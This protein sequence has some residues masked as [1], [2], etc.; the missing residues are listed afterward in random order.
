VAFLR[1]DGKNFVNAEFNSRRKWICNTYYLM[2]SICIS[3]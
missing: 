3:D 2:F 1:L